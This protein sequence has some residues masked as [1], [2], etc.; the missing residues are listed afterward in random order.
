M[1]TPKEIP[2]KT[3][4]NKAVV[5]A[6]WTVLER[7]GVSG[8]SAV[9]VLIFARYVPPEE[10]GFFA[11]FVMVSGFA[12][13]IGSL[14]AEYTIIQK[15]DL[16]SRWLNTLFTMVCLGSLA[17][18]CLVIAYSSAVE[19]ALKHEGIAVAL[20]IV[21]VGTFFQTVT[22]ILTA[23]LRRKLNMEA[24]AKRALLANLLSGLVATP[25]VV[26]GFGVYAL[27]IQFVGGQFVT[28]I[29]T[30]KLTDDFPR[31][32]LNLEAVRS[33]LVLGGPLVFSDLVSH[34]T[35][36]SPKL[37]VGGILGFEALGLF[38]IASRLINVLT[39]LMGNC[40]IRVCLPVFSEVKRNN[41]D[42]STAFIRVV[43]LATLIAFPVFSFV[44]V[45][46]SQIVD[47]VLSDAWI[48]ISIFFPLLVIAGLLMATAKVNAAIIITLG[49]SSLQMNLSFVR[50]L[51][52]TTLLVILVRQGLVWVSV[53][54][55]LR[56]AIVEPMF[57]FY[58]LKSL[59]LSLRRYIRCI[60]GAS[61]AT[62][63]C[64]LVSLIILTF[65]A[66]LTSINVLLVSSIFWIACY[67]LFLLVLDK[68]AVA[69]LQDLILIFRK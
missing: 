23:L 32:A 61:L 25:F 57:L 20:C 54:V 39:N 63:C 18:T 24:L 21:A 27:I 1:L 16:S 45:F 10:L 29:L 58:S 60:A 48:S 33:I 6:G 15:E 69:E 35:R 30:V 9:F 52:G 12:S 14:G 7:I 17:I 2:L 13:K 8:L 56:A 59:D 43:R 34:Y 55:L 22:L 26:G 5:A 36:E 53:A 44:T 11:G 46:S 4:K 68:S 41:G 37:F 66:S 47:V 31:P 50:A 19:E 49:M 64:I 40:L 51:V 42:L 38:S 62:G 67:P 3:L 65:G 28:F